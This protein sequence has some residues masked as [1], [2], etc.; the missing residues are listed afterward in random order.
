MVPG[1]GA[2]P[3]CRLLCCLL[4]GDTSVSKVHAQVLLSQGPAGSAPLTA[5]L[6]DLSRFGTFVNSTKMAQGSDP[7]Q[8]N[9][10]DVL[11]L[12]STRSCFRCAAAMLVLL[13]CMCSR[14]P[15]TGGVGCRVVAAW[16]RGCVPP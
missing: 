3:C 12:G 9:D 1:Q 13:T 15:C 8:L 4:A 14:M 6:Q 16:M 5:Q 2:D 11:R 7:A 10:G